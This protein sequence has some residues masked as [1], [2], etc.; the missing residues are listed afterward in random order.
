MKHT[1][2]LILFSREASS[3]TWIN[4]V[5]RRTALSAISRSR[6][7]VF[8]WRVCVYLKIF[9]VLLH[10]DRQRGIVERERYSREMIERE[11][12]GEGEGER[13]A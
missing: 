8:A 7:R 5:W 10:T 11:G 6:A 4:G 2:D 13:D 3:S 1:I 12:E 9:R